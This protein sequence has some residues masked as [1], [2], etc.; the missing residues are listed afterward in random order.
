MAMPR[1]IY[2]YMRARSAAV[3]KAKRKQEKELRDAEKARLKRER[4]W[5]RANVK[6][7][8]DRHKA[9]E[10]ARHKVR[11]EER[12]QQMEERIEA[13][14]RKQYGLPKDG[15]LVIVMETENRRLEI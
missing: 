3:R 1:S 13:K 7:E 4:E 10:A 6:A 12:L 15:T 8:R 2:D 11:A 9:M 14:L 5:E